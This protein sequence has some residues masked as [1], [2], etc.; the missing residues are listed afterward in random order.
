MSSSTTTITVTVNHLTKSTL[1]ELAKTL[2]LST[3]EII[4]RLAHT[5]Y[6]KDPL[7][8]SFLIMESF[9]LYTHKME[10]AQ[11]DKTIELTL[12]SIEACV[13]SD[14]PREIT[15]L[16]CSIYQLLMQKKAQA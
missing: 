15:D 2:A 14:E 9:L 13:K 12:Q 1:D 6:S 5:C 16:L 11:F 3:G 8:A 7:Q 10:Q 4:D